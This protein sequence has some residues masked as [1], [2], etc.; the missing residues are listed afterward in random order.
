MFKHAALKIFYRSFIELTNNPL[1][2][3]LLKRFCES[4]MSKPMIPLFSKYYHINWNDVNGSAAEYETLS[5]LFIRNIN[6]ELRPVAQEENAVVSPVDGVVQT[7][8]KINSNQTYRVKGKDYSF[9]ELTGFNSMEHNY[10]GG[11][12]AVLYLSPR[13]YHRFHSPIS[14]TYQK[15]AE[16]G[17]RSYPVNQLGLTYGKDV[18]SKNYR[19][20]YEL[21][22]DRQKMLMIPVGAMNINTIVQTSAKEHLKL[23]E[24]L[25]Y[26]SFGSTVILIFEKH[27]FEPAADLTEG[28]EVQVGQAIGYVK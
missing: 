24:E 21:T 13:H 15:L 22:G 28:R 8:G 16:L 11:Y 14:C 19:Y 20:V 12:F 1:T 4:K 23:G 17:K 9:A 2:S 27:A 3:R 25:G 18:L 10:N 5:A 7:V 6:L 26:F